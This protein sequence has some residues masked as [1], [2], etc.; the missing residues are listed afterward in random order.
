[1]R[2]KKERNFKIKFSFSRVFECIVENNIQH[3]LEIDNKI[4][5]IQYKSISILQNNILNIKII[6]SKID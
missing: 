6:I 5:N 3:N 4:L 1:M 2:K